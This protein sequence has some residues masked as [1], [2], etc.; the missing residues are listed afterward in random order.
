MYIHTKLAHCSA[1]NKVNQQ[2][3]KNSSENRAF[4]DRFCSRHHVTMITHFLQKSHDKTLSASS[5]FLP[6][7]CFSFSPS[8][9]AD[10]S[11]FWS[12]TIDRCPAAAAAIGRTPSPNFFEPLAQ[13]R[14]KFSILES[15]G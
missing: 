10:I 7:F 6:S 11:A 15:F 12:L 1:C 8:A 13:S 2:E 4:G 14:P 3:D 5:P 9:E